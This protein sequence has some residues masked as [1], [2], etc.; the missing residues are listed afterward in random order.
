MRDA[1]HPLTSLYLE[2]GGRLR[3]YAVHG[4]GQLYD[5]ILPG[6]GNI[7]V[8]FVEDRV[9]KTRDAPGDDGYLAAADGVQHELAV[10]IQV[11]AGA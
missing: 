1:G 5:G 8:A 4:Y 11:V 9:V 2:Q 6:V 3:C 10:P 7:G